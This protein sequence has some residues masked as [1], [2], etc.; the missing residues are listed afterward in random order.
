MSNQGDQRGTPPQNPGSQN[1]VPYERFKQTIDE[2]NN[3]KQQN[4]QLRQQVDHIYQNMT[5]Q[6]APQQQQVEE[7]T[8]FE[9]QTVKAMRSLFQKELDRTVTP[10]AQQFRQQLGGMADENDKLRFMIQ[11][12]PQAYG[13]H[14]QKIEQLRQE[15]AN[16][17]QWVSREDAYKFVRYDET[18][19]KP[20]E[21]PVKPL[22]ASLDP[23]T[24]E[25]VEQRQT[26]PPQ[27]P[28]QQMQQQPPPQ[29]EW[30]EPALPPAGIV[31]GGYVPP[32]SGAPKLSIASTEQD[33]K[34]WEEQFGTKQF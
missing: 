15:R 13:E 6:Q 16:M 8:P 20:K 31:E 3:L 10:M 17:G 22:G 5:R 29:E 11:Y 34:A 14:Q 30:N 32:Q 2:V 18:G 9:P 7:D 26:P 21:N 1:T 24:G 12:G 33:L 19:H 28:P 27:A 25:I 4:Q 23:Y